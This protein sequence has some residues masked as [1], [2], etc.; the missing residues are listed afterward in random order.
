[1]RNILSGS[2]MA[3]TAVNVKKRLLSEV[4]ALQKICLSF[5][6]IGLEPDESS[7]DPVAIQVPS[8]WR[9]IILEDGLIA[10]YFEGYRSLDP[11]QCH[12]AKVLGLLASVRRSFFPDD[13][14]REKYLNRLMLGITDLIKNSVNMKSAESYHHT[15]RLLAR[16]A[17]IHIFYV[18]DSTPH[19]KN[20]VA[21]ALKFTADGLS[22]WEASP[23]SV[24]P[25]LT[26]WYR[27]SV[28][29]ERVASGSSEKDPKLSADI[30]PEIIKVYLMAMLNSVSAISAGESDADNP[31]DN[32]D[33]LFGNLLMLAKMARNSYKVCAEMLSMLLEQA[34]TNYQEVIHAAMPSEQAISEIETKL[35]W[36]IY[37]TSAFFE[38]RVPYASLPE[39]DEWD[40]LLVSRVM[41]LDRAVLERINKFSRPPSE[42]LELSILKFYQN[43]RKA[44]LTDQGYRQTKIFKHLSTTVNINDV[45][46]ALAHIVKKVMY[47]LEV[48]PASSRV[49]PRSLDI[50][51]E[52]S[53][54]YTML[55]QLAKMELISE[56][57]KSHGGSRFKFLDVVGDRRAR[58][59]FYGSLCRILAAKGLDETSFSEFVESWTGAVDGLLSLSDEV[60]CEEPAKS[61]ALRMLYDLRG[62]VAA[63]SSRASFALFFDWFYP[64]RIGLIHRTVALYKEDV[65]MQIAALRLMA[66]FTFNSSQRLNF[67]VS[68]ANGILMFREASNVIYE[69]TG[70]K[71][72]GARACTDVYKERYKGMGLCFSILTNVLSGNYVAVG[73]MP[74]YGDP[75]LGNAFTA[76][77]GL[78]K[79]I[80]VSDLLSYPKLAGWT[81]RLLETIFRES[82]AEFVPID[83]ETYG[84]VARICLEALGHVKQAVMASACTV[85]DNLC[86]YAL[87][88]QHRRKRLS[89]IVRS[90]RDILRALVRELLNILLFE[91]HFGEWSLSR[92]LFVL[93][94]LEK[95]YALSYVN[96]VSQYQSLE[97]REPLVKGLIEL[98]SC[99]FSLKFDCRDRFTQAVNRYHR[100]MRA[101]GIVL[102]MPTS[103]TKSLASDLMTLGADGKV[104][105]VGIVAPQ[106]AETDLTAMAD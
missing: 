30:Y 6:F 46:S 1:M 105:A 2:A 48:W 37:M 34:A 26:F 43:F 45:E 98:F 10:A 89:E 92:P 29:I 27:L 71:L 69:Y 90:E 47:D 82:K 21:L 41:V 95:E 79:S 5:D 99:D 74:L 23:N 67:E 17:S 7:D 102:M 18:I 15:C 49:I 20:F 62:F 40:S 103:Q 75:A 70:Q 13:S 66:E 12:E 59:Q 19:F 65:A 85:I 56:L 4:L 39:D 38:A 93:I 83:V 14:I 52:M 84:H 81:M 76:V 42:Y 57:L 9:D 25:L 11:P 44:Y 96:W 77:I 60:F 36:L 8:S 58:M 64:H 97:V 104:E 86:T 72:K 55:R 3:S 73:V 32:E 16:F 88:H 50:L 87:E 100:N 31:L 80:P 54:G 33:E 78:L 63:L 22:L 101:K 53:A 91:E 106:A 35:A 24:N 68:S 94:I 51:H 61:R 28:E